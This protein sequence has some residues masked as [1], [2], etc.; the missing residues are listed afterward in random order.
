MVDKKPLEYQAR[1]LN[2]LTEPTYKRHAIRKL[3]KHFE[4]KGWV[5]SQETGQY[6][7]VSDSEEIERDLL[8]ELNKKI[9]AIIASDKTGA[10][11]S[12]E[13]LL[14]LAETDPDKFMNYYQAAIEANPTLAEKEPDKNDPN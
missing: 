6:N 3:E 9:I 4:S 2:A 5:F 12:I 10:A 1:I 14:I 7:E 11:G 8:L 13:N